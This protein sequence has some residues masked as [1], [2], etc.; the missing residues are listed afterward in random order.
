MSV[1]GFILLMCVH[2]Y[3]LFAYMLLEGKDNVLLIVTLGSLCHSL[4]LL[5]RHRISQVTSTY[6]SRE[7]MYASPCN[8]VK[9]LFQ[10]S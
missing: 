6:L 4:R 3:L 9:F 2:V 5:V 10:F 8:R 7:N 1:S